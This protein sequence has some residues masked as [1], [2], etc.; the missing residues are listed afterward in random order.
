M[1]TA[2]CRTSTGRPDW[3]DISPRIALGN[4]YAAQ[5]FAQAD[6]ELG[7]LTRQFAAGDFAPLCGWLGE[8]IHHLGQKFTAAELV[9]QVTGKPLSHRPLIEHLRG[10]LGPLYGLA[11]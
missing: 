4:L 9:N 1:P 2:C 8:K 5:F 6:A 10:K 3:S 11:S 7:G